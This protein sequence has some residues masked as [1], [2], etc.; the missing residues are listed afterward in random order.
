MKME[1]GEAKTGWLNENGKWYYFNSDCK[2]QTGWIKVDGKK[3]Y[4]YSDGSMAV[5]TTING[6]YLGSDGAATR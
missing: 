4:L 5:N 1:N 2:M 6:I 3:Y